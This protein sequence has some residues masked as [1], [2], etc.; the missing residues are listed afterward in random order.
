M[1]AAK[2]L[3]LP[4]LAL[5]AVT[6]GGCKI[7]VEPRGV[8]VEPRGVVVTATALAVNEKIY[9]ETDSPEILSA[10]FG[11]LNA[12]AA[13]LND[14]PQIRLVEVQGHA[15]GRNTDIYNLRLTL[16]RANSVVQYLV[17]QGVDPGRL[18]AAGYGERCPLDP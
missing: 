1:R 18:I 9:F 11:I 4:M 17:R 12:V 6:A 14:T 13:T 5:L 2:R 15:D 10:S 7:F 3:Q 16:D 8:V